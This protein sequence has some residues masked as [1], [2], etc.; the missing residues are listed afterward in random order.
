MSLV[1]EPPVS[2]PLPPAIDDGSELWEQFFGSLGYHQEDDAANGDALRMWSEGLMHPLQ[3]MYDLVRPRAGR[4]GWDIL[5]DPD[6]AP[7]YALPF[8]AMIGGVQLTPEMG[9][10]QQRDEIRQPTGWKRGWLETLQIVTRRTLEPVAD[11]ELLVIIH[12]GTPAPGWH[13]IRTLLSQ[14]PEPD[15]TKVVLRAKLPA[16]ERM[17]YEAI[18]GPTVADVAASTK[19]TTVADLAAAFPT[20]QAL[21]EILPTEL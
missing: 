4:A 7:A 5:L 8:P 9:E 13:Y 16:W 1:V 19:W 2:P 21:T 6:D 3:A 14:T 12:A 10:Q 17:D 11:E 15:R 20:V 18:A